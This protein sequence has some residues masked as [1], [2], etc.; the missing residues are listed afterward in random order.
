EYQALGHKGEAGRIACASC[1]VP[2]SG[3]IDSRSSGHS[4]SLAAAWGRRR[5]PALLDVAQLRLLTWDGRH[6]DLYNQVFSPL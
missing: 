2:Q 3:F 1:H 4:I 5:A 6:D